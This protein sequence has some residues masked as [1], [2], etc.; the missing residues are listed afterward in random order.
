MALDDW[1]DRNPEVS[2]KINVTRHPYSWAGDDIEAYKRGRFLE[3]DKKKGSEFQQER[4][5]RGNPQAEFI[6]LK[7]LGKQAGI[8]Y[9]HGAEMVWQPIDAQRLLLWAS[10]YGYQEQLA[11]EISK[12]HFEEARSCADTLNLLAAVERSA[13]LS[14]EEAKAFLETDELR[15]YVWDSYGEMIRY[16]G[17]KEIPTF[18][19]NH[20][21]TPNAFDA[22]FKPDSPT[23]YIVVGATPVEKIC[24]VFDLLWQEA[25]VSSE[26]GLGSTPYHRSRL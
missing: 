3:F 7:E 1:Q 16:W 15:Q 12:L 10:R 23:P 19:F 13:G 21:H 9:Q 4:G 24:M 22:D 18:V 2:L 20:L 6:P 5:E 26:V 14:V 11:D 17:I 25:Q 8:T